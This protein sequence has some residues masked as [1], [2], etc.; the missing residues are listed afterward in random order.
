METTAVKVD[1]RKIIRQTMVQSVMVVRF[2][3][4]VSVVKITNIQSVHLEIFVHH[5]SITL[6][7]VFPFKI[8]LLIV[9]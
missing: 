2:R 5:V 4:Q 6:R 9:C 1:L 8:V 3:L 7:M